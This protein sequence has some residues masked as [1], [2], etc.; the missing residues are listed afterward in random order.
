MSV[1]TLS[2]SH[3][4]GIRRSFA[5]ATRTP[6]ALAE[7]FYRRLFEAEPGFR[8]MFPADLTGQERKLTAILATAVASIDRLD[9][10]VPAVENLG[11]RHQALGVRHEHYA[12]VGAALIAAIED[13]AGRPLDAAARE[14]WRRAFAWLTATMTGV[15][16]EAPPA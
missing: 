15:G 4:E 13:C 2:P 5:A 14:G 9:A 1:H 10:L 7:T 6:G 3:A 16:A 8:A 11:R 12:P